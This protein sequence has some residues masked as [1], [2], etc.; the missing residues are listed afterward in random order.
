MSKRLIK[1]SLFQLL[2][3]GGITVGYVWWTK[4]DWQKSEADAKHRRFA[5]GIIKQLHKD[6]PKKEFSEAERQAGR[7]RFEE[8]KKLCSTREALFEAIKDN[9][10]HSLFVLGKARESGSF[11]T[12]GG[13]CKESFENLKLHYEKYYSLKVPT[14]DN[15]LLPRLSEENIPFQY[16]FRSRLMMK[17]FW[18]LEGKFRCIP[19][20]RKILEVGEEI[21]EFSFKDQFQYHLGERYLADG[22]STWT[23]V[24]GATCKQSFSS[25]F[26]FDEAGLYAVQF[27][28]FPDATLAKTIEGVMKSPIYYVQ[29]EEK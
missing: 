18:P 11:F 24:G 6:E 7:A 26:I 12:F 28:Y 25:G 9:Y 23:K 4:G 3:A 22:G 16:A 10:E 29:V 5:E 8:L 1:I 15:L 13:D 21:S 2:L 20:S 17:V 19:F 27:H 14:N